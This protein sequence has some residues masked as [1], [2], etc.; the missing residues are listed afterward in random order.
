MKN[1][2]KGFISSLLVI[3]IAALVVGGGV[4]IYKKEKIE[5]PIISAVESAQNDLPTTTPNPVDET[6][7]PVITSISQSSGPIGT[8]I[9]LK[10]Q[11]LAGFEGD[12]DAIIENSRG[13]TAFL[14]G[15]GYVPGDYKTIRVKIEARICKTNNSY[16][17]LPCKE[18]LDIVPGTYKIF[19]SPWGKTSNK[20]QFIVTSSQEL[21]PLTLYIQNREAT[22]RTEGA[23]C[24]VTQKVVYQVP[25]TT[26][27]ADTSLKILFQQELAPYGKYKSVT[28]VNRVAKV[29][30]TSDKDATGKSVGSLSSCQTQH[31]FAVLKDTLT[32]YPSITSVELHSPQGKI[33]F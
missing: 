26:A 22:I 13:E 14:K 8:I 30:L 27:V 3:I 11:N 24:G 21:M 33:E 23:D 9:E 7:L 12:L 18:Y 6:P 25:K 20:V 4:Y 17:G 32:Q 28:I 5:D 16:S 2:K 31:L 15:I 19:T 29:M 10:G 1:T